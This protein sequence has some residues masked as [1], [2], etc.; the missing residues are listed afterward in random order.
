MIGYIML[1][2]AAAL[3]CLALA[4]KFS[5]QNLRRVFQPRRGLA[6]ANTISD[7]EFANGKYSRL[8]D[9][10]IAIYTLCEYGTDANHVK[11]WAGTNAPLFA[12]YD[13]IDADEIARLEPVPVRALGKGPT[14][15]LLPAAAITAGS[16]IV[17][18]SATK[19]GKV[20][21]TS[22]GGTAWVIGIANT[23]AVA[24]DPFFELIDCQPYTVTIGA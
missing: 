14:K 2:L 10:A 21:P 22:G 24:G 17:A 3:G 20:L 16:L 11:P 1:M 15:R 23:P 9:A 4:G 13:A 7:G 8:A 19:G 6:A 5:K 12:S 18:D